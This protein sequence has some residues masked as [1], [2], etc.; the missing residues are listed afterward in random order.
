MG[1]DRAKGKGPKNGVQGV[2][3]AVDRPAFQQVLSQTFSD[4]LRS[5]GFEILERGSKEQVTRLHEL[6]RI[7]REAMIHCVRRDYRPDAIS[8]FVTV[9]GQ[10]WE[11]DI[12]EDGEIEWECFRS[13][14]HIGDESELKE[15][16][17]EFAEPE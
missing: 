13:N 5:G 4:F 1:S 3:E 2:Q 8:L 17:S 6:E 9:P 11:I 14:G 16:I 7:L 15:A 10:R 12:M